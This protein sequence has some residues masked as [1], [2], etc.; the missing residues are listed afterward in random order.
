MSSRQKAEGGS[1]LGTW[2]LTVLRLRP[3]TVP[4][5]YRHLVRM[6]D[7]Q[8]SAIQHGVEQVLDSKAGRALDTGVP[9]HLATLVD[10]VRPVA[11]ETDEDWLWTIVAM[12]WLGPR[13]AGAPPT[14]MREHIQALLRQFAPYEQ[15]RLGRV[16]EIVIAYGCGKWRG[17]QPGS[18]GWEHRWQGAMRGLVRAME[19]S[20]AQSRRWL[21]THV[22]GFPKEREEP[23]SVFSLEY[24]AEWSDAWLLATHLLSPEKRLSL[25][26]HEVLTLECTPEGLALMVEAQNYQSFAP[27]GAKVVWTLRERDGVVELSHGQAFPLPAQTRMLLIARDDDT[28]MKTAGEDHDHQARIRLGESAS[29][30]GPATID[31]HECTCGTTHCIERHRLAAWD[32]ARQVP[33]TEADGDQ[34]RKEGALTLWDYVASAIKGPQTTIKTGA[35]VQGMYFPLLTQEGVTL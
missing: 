8:V 2:N 6:M 20:V 19:P 12:C 30:S 25:R 27:P 4:E 13:A 17:I 9:A 10:A 21:K 3:L 22:V 32:P 33:K 26:E 15:T 23:A 28:I 14:P 24:A 1:I 5:R 16:M 11:P 31:L 7:D 35:F 29:L 18:G 34:V